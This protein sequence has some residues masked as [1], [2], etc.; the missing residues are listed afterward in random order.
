MPDQLPTIGSDSDPIEAVPVMLFDSNS[1]YAPAIPLYLQTG[2]G[3][4]DGS[5]RLRVDPAQTSFFDKRE[6]TFSS[7]VSVPTSNK[8]LFRFV[9]TGDFIVNNLSLDVD[10]NAL[11]LTTWSGGTPTGTFSAATPIAANTMAEG[12]V[13]PASVMTVSLTAPGAGVALTGGTQIDVLRLAA[14]NA[15]AQAST[16]GAAQDSYRGRAAGTYYIMLENIGSG[17]ATGVLHIRWEQR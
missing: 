5:I 2:I 17:A 7:E 15:A 16:I 1:A 13:A 8:Q 10:A 4:G 9:S 3:Q 11:R 6:Y 12:P 14:A